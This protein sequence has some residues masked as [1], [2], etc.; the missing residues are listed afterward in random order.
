M[1]VDELRAIIV[2]VF[3]QLTVEEVI[4]RLDAAQIANARMNDMHDVWEH[5]QLRRA[6]LDRGRDAGGAVSAL[7]PP[8]LPEWRIRRG[9][10]PC[11]RSAS[12]PRL[13]RRRSA[14]TADAIARLREEH[15]I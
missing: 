2:E 1:R 8:G 9:W 14:T 10:T 5:P 3:A 11:L 6:T 13:L 12:T 7:L 15:A 4:A